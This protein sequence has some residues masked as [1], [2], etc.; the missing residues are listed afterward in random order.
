MCSLFGSKKSTDIKWKSQVIP[1]VI[2][3]MGYA[4]AWELGPAADDSTDST[5]TQFLDKCM[6]K[7][8]NP[9]PE[10]RFR[11]NNVFHITIKTY[12]NHRIIRYE[13]LILNMTGY[14]SGVFRFI[15]CLYL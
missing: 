14:S 1:Q 9:R 4:L 12:K 15:H 11:L 5:G 6:G 2:R 10:F 7:N 3:D 8:A 13:E